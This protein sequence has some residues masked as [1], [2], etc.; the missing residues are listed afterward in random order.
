MKHSSLILSLI[1]LLSI[2]QTSFAAQNSQRKSSQINVSEDVDTLGGNEE[3]IKMAQSLKSRTR[4]RIVQDRIVDRKNR[5][6]FALSYGGIIGGDSYLQ[7]QAVGFAANFHINPRWSLGVQ[8]SDF[9]NSLTPEGKRVFDQYRQTQAA[10]GVP[11][12][13]VD[14]DY[15]INATMAVINWYPI[16]GKTSFLDMGITQFDIYL[17]GGAGQI[18]LSSGDAPIYSAGLGIGAWLSPHVSMRAEFKYQ[19]YR[20]QPITGSRDLNTGAANVGMGWIL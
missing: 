12:T 13:A 8:Y 6:E 7:T 19:T 10:G 16:Y 11:A 4:T 15:P 17:I 1:F 3:L 2:G 9:S 14:V 5:L 18:K 20:D